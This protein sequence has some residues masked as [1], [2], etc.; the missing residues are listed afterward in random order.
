MAPSITVVVGDRNTQETH[1]ALRSIHDRWEPMRAVVYVPRK[2]AMRDRVVKALPF[3]GGLASDPDHA[4]VYV[5]ANGGCRR[6]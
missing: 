1:D 4:V 6:R 5:C 3:V 2:G